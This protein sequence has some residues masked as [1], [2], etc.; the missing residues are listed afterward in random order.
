MKNLFLF[1]LSFIIYT[2]VAY[3]NLDEAYYDAVENGYWRMTD[4]PA[5]DCSGSPRFYE[6]H[7]PDNE[8][9]EF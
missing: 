3:V 7:T 8:E 5:Y 9:I 6:R 2:S 4:T 1:I